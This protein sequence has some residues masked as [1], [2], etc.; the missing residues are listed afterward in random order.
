[1]N[2]GVALAIVTAVSGVLA[3]LVTWLGY[4]LT[5]QSDVQARSD[6]HIKTLIKAELEPLI[7]Q[8]ADILSGLGQ[9]RDQ[10]VRLETAL[11]KQTE[12]QGRTLDRLAVLETK[13]EVFWKNV[14][15]NA[16]QIL[17]SPDP[18]RAHIDKLLEAFRDG[19]LDD[20]GYTELM[21]IL[22]KVVAY[23]PGDDLGFPIHPGEQ[24][25]A[26]AILAVEEAMR[27]G[28]RERARHA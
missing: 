10:Q 1:M 11:D 28:E 4:R 17:H 20:R 6:E 27:A 24:F 21:G 22:E 5:K 23:E 18:A 15:M 2:A 26:G 3:V 12:S 8:Q 9:L 16:T 7:K 14:T 13:T 25:A 19:K